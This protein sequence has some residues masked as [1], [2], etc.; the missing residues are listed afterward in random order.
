MPPGPLCRDRGRA[1]AYA[2]IE[3]QVALVGLGLDKIFEEGDG[4]LRAVP[5]IAI[6]VI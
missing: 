5:N 2:V 1:G 4:L 6:V 3:N